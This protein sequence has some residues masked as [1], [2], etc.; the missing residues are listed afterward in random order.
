MKKIQFD[1]NYFKANPNTKLVCRN[2]RL[3]TLIFLAEKKNIDNYPLVFVNQNGII[4][5]YTY[6]GLYLTNKEDQRDIFMLIFSKE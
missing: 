1:Y 2:E 5:R 4:E 6:E 3:G